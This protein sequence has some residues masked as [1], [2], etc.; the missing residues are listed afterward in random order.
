[1]ARLLSI[2]LIL[3]STAIIGLGILCIIN[4]DFIVGR[5]PQAAFNPF[6]VYL[7][8]IV[9]I[10]AALAVAFQKKGYEAA[11][12]IALCILLFSVSRHLIAGMSDW[13]N[14]YKSLALIGGTVVIAESFKRQS[15]HGMLWLGYILLAV[16]FVACGYAHIK[17]YDFVVNFIPVY[18]PFHG[19]FTYFTAG[20]LIAGGIGLL[21]PVTRKWAGYLSGIMVGGWFLLLHIPRVI[22]NPSDAGER[23]GLFE[24]LAFSAIFFIVAVLQE[25]TNER[26]IP[27]FSSGKL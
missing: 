7:L 1:M 25:R 10:L 27:D 2:S 24:S 17:F 9:I 15:S 22:D 21:I 8:S 4:N 26:A 11:L 12:A 14:T 16:F 5:P 6:I 18:I 20:C 19:F 13:L 3:Y 23:M